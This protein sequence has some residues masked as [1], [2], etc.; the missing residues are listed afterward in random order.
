MSQNGAKHSYQG[1]ILE[2]QLPGAQTWHMPGFLKLEAVRALAPDKGCK[3]LAYPRMQNSSL[4]AQ[5]KLHTIF[6]KVPA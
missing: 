3:A 2:K 4:N 6:L 5:G 1:S